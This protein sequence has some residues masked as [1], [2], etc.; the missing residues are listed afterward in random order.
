MYTT[1]QLVLLNKIGII[2][3]LDY[4]KHINFLYF[5]LNEKLLRHPTGLFQPTQK[6]THFNSNLF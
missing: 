1:S 2:K 4:I 6:V 3:N 5:K